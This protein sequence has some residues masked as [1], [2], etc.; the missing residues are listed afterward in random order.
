V[1]EARMSEPE[2]PFYAIGALVTLYIA[3]AIWRSKDAACRPAEQLQRPIEHAPTVD[4]RV[5]HWWRARR[6]RKSPSATR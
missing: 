3:A 6:R 5:V 1:A 4:R 2:L